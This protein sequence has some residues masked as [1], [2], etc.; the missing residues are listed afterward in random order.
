ML[1]ASVKSHWQR[2]WVRE[3]EGIRLKM[4]ASGWR[5]LWHKCHPYLWY[6]HSQWPWPLLFSSGSLQKAILE[7][8][9]YITS[10]H[11]KHFPVFPIMQDQSIYWL[12]LIGVLP[13]VCP[14]TGSSKLGRPVCRSLCIPNC[15]FINAFSH[16]LASTKKS[17][18]LIVER[19]LKGQHIPPKLLIISYFREV[20]KTSVL[21]SSNLLIWPK[22]CIL[23]V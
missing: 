16:T 9:L 20:A 1:Q 19:S 10:K 12:V 13:V 3:T 2:Q 15:L 7:R 5:H 17:A 4:P 14:W 18:L 8:R 22:Y 23:T 21:S 11:C 6:Y